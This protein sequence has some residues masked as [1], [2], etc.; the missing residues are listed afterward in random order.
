VADRICF[1]IVDGDDGDGSL[2]LIVDGGFGHVETLAA[3]KTV[4]GR[5]IGAGQRRNSGRFGDEVDQLL[6]GPD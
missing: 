4:S 3:G 5:V 1:A 2:E 6:D